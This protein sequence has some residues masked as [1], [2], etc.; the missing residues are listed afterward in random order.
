MSSTNSTSKEAINL[1]TELN[2]L[3]S[4]EIVPKIL[5]N[6]KIDIKNQSG[7]CNKKLEINCNNTN[8]IK[9]VTSNVKNKKGTISEQA[10]T[11]R[12]SIKDR[13]VQNMKSLTKYSALPTEN[14]NGINDIISTTFKS[15]MSNIPIRA[16]IEA[17]ETTTVTNLNSK[18]DQNNTNLLINPIIEMEKL[19]TQSEANNASTVN[20][21]LTDSSMSASKG[22]ETKE[23][24]MSTSACTLTTISERPPRIKRKPKK[25]ITDFT[26]LP[27]KRRK[28]SITVSNSLT[29]DSQDEKYYE[30]V[31]LSKNN[32]HENEIGLD[33]LHCGQVT[34]SND[35]VS[36]KEINSID[37][38][39]ITND[40]TI[41]DIGEKYVGIEEVAKEDS[42]RKKLQTSTNTLKKERKNKKSRL[43]KE[44]EIDMVEG[45]P[46]L[47]ASQL[48]K[49]KSRKSASENLSKT[50]NLEPKQ[51]VIS[52][53]KYKEDCVTTINEAVTES[54]NNETIIEKCT[55]LNQGEVNKEIDTSYNVPQ[56]EDF[57]ESSQDS[58]VSIIPAKTPK[59][60][61]KKQT[62]QTVTLL[63]SIRKSSKS[64]MSELIPANQEA[65]NN[66]NGQELNSSLVVEKID[67]TANM[68]TQPLMSV[69]EN[70]LNINPNK[71]NKSS[72]ELKDSETTAVNVAT[73][74]TEPLDSS[75]F[76]NNINAENDTTF[77]ISRDT[78]DSKLDKDTTKSVT[79]TTI[80][81]F[82]E[83][84]SHIS[85]KN[86]ATGLSSPFKDEV[87][88]NEDFLNNTL[89]ISPIKPSSPLTDD[90]KVTLPKNSEEYVVITLSSPV[91]S[92]GEP[93]DRSNSP[94]VFNDVDKSIN[95]DKSPIKDNT[96]SA[97]V[98]PDKLHQS[99]PREMASLNN[100][101]PRS[102]SLKRNRPQMKPI[103][104]AAHMLGCVLGVSN[105]YTF[106]D[107]EKFNDMVDDRSSPHKKPVRRN[108][109]SSYEDREDN[110][111]FLKFSKEVPSAN[112]SPSCP[113]LKRKHANIADDVNVS[114]AS[115]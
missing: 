102:L 108:L 96:D 103:G 35:N 79:I 54:T 8:S 36:L 98:S 49:R 81:D 114:P 66:E 29:Q 11:P 2:K 68:D 109:K 105:K 89:D 47:S 86:T 97:N 93:A 21:D 33:E 59:R 25:L 84:V 110:G 26:E 82:N 92:N 113:I 31:E 71:E 94:E 78:S 16:S 20:T 107:S 67:T 106:M 43:E 40:T 87:Q 46:F 7:D 100:N 23:A 28:N 64:K 30:N 85:D 9:V 70:I 62:Q 32:T 53:N 80:P 39:Q 12:L 37:E 90:K 73:V 88:R 75:V 3:S 4:A 91:H 51:S 48:E 111:I 57:I 56:S 74:D 44:L 104:R 52:T 45:H 38:F 14:V 99:P 1:S 41:K 58:A 18:V 15:D 112:S 10:L 42:S 17:K 76:S 19:H 50:N 55:A 22:N 5:D 27:S 6:M 69:E 95:K 13:I 101:S 72:T 34:G 61:L 24:I 77:T 63:K 83:L 60:L 115:K 65:L